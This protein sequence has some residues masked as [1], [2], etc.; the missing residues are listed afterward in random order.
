MRLQDSTVT[1]N[2]K[3]VIEEVLNSLKRQHNA[4]DG[5]LYDYTKHLILH[6]PQLYNRTQRRDVHRTPFPILELD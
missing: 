2:P 4:E 6:L 1:N 5:E 3:V